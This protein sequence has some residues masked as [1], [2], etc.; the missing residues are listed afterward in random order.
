MAAQSVMDG[1]V[2]FSGGQD[3]SKTPERTPVN[4]YYSGIN[5]STEDGVISPR[6]GAEELLLDF[7]DTDL[8]L[9]NGTTRSYLNIFEYGKFQAYIPYSI[10][11]EF[12]QL[13]IISGIIYVVNQQTLEVSIMTIQGGSQLD[14]AADRINWSPAG[15][16]L[17]IFDFPAYPVIVEG[18]LARRADPALYEIPR[19][20]LGTYNQNRLFIANA[21]NEF[22]AGDPAAY[23]FPTGPISFTEILAPAAPYIGQSFQL[24][25]DYNDDTITAMGFLQTVDTSTGI[26]PLLISSQ[27]SIYSYQTQNPRAQWEG[28]QFG[29]LFIHDTGIAGQRAF[30]NV[31]GDL[32]FVDLDGTL[33]TASMSRA[34]QQKWSKTPISREVKNFLVSTNKELLPYT[35]LTY[36][37]NK[38]FIT[39]N[40]YRVIATTQLGAPI[41]DYVFGGFVVLETDNLAGLGKDSQPAWAGLWTFTRPMDIIQNNKEAYVIGKAEDGRNT[42]Y[43]LRPDLS[44]DIIGPQRQIRKIKA[45]VY[46][47]SYGFESPFTNKNLNYIEPSFNDIKGEFSFQVYYKPSHGSQ[48]SY[49]TGFKHNAPWESC[50]IPE[51]CAW[52]GLLGHNFRELNLGSPADRACDPI[53][54]DY[55]DVFRKVQLYFEIEGIDWQ[56]DEFQLNAVVL[57]QNTTERVCEEYPSDISICGKCNTDWEIPSLC[58]E[59]EQT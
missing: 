53:T 48:F 16:Y 3:A 43:K 12:F 51:G 28:S 4:A 10:G 52:K 24:S 50:L 57:P 32:F 1:T 54:E 13:I 46:T 27:N 56:L 21:G 30:C 47:R 38:I 40:P 19:S 33:R 55:L 36:I 31:N 22:T 29:G 18:L 6:W 11:S 26:G 17:V 5:V 9:S 34:E 45:K 20:V 41:F 7:P 44:Y 58:Q 42:V 2:D 49:W 39:A 35:V 8:T 23:T 59:T 37:K 25:T 15:K 14:E